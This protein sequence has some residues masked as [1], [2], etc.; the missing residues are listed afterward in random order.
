MNNVINWAMHFLQIN[1]NLPKRLIIFYSCYS[2]SSLQ[3]G[4][5]QEMSLL[6]VIVSYI[7]L[8]YFT[9]WSRVMP[10]TA[11]KNLDNKW[12]VKICWGLIM[13]HWHCSE[14]IGVEIK[15]S[16]TLQTQFTIFDAES[17]KS[18]RHNIF[19]LLFIVCPSICRASR[20]LETSGRGS[21]S[22]NICRPSVVEN[23]L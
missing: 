23:T 15:Q 12:P 21:A 3:L 10:E 22:E 17:R 7:V 11:G 14:A 20:V 18:S 13:I 19:L 9:I 6:H 4:D 8:F 5:C 1:Q 16:Q 2:I